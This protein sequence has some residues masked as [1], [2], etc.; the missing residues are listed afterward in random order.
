M[1]DGLSPLTSD[2]LHTV[3]IKLDKN[4]FIDS[5]IRSQKTFQ[6]SY[7][8]EGLVYSESWNDSQKER[9]QELSEI[10]KPAASV[11]A[12]S[13]LVPR[14]PQARSARQKENL[15]PDNMSETSQ[16]VRDSLQVPAPSPSPKP[17]QNRKAL[18]SKTPVTKKV[19]DPNP[20]TT[21]KGRK[22]QRSHDSEHTA[23][24]NE[25]KERRRAKQAIVKPVVSEESEPESE[26]KQSR[27]RGKKTTQPK[28]PKLAAGLS[29]MHGFKAQNLGK[30]RI[31]LEPSG[32]L[33]SKGRASGK[34]AVTK[35][36]KS[37]PDDAKSGR[38]TEATFLASG[39]KQRDDART[40]EESSKNDTTKETVHASNTKMNKL[41][42]CNYDIK[43]RT[44]GRPS[45]EPSPEPDDEQRSMMWDIERSSIAPADVHSATDRQSAPREI[46]VSPAKVKE[47]V[48]RLKRSSSA[49]PGS[50]SDHH[51]TAGEEQDKESS[52][53]SLRPSQSAS[54]VLAVANPPPAEATSKY[55]VTKATVVETCEDNRVDSKTV[56]SL[57]EHSEAQESPKTG[58]F[59]DS[60]VPAACRDVAS[61]SAYAAS[62]ISPLNHS[63][64]KTSGSRVP[65]SSVA[66]GWQDALGY[67]EPSQYTEDSLNAYSRENL[68]LPREERHRW[69]GYSSDQYE[70]RQDILVQENSDEHLK[71][72]SS[73]DSAMQPDIDNS[74]GYISGNMD[75]PDLYNGSDDQYDDHHCTKTSYNLRADSETGS[76]SDMVYEA[77]ADGYGSEFPEEGHNSTE[78]DI[79]TSS[80][81]A[82]MVDEDGVD[83][84]VYM[85]QEED[86]CMYY[87]GLKSGSE[88]S[89]LG[90]E[91]EEQLEFLHGRELLLGMADEGFGASSEVSQIP[92]YQTVL[93]AEETVA[94]QLKGHWQ[95]QRF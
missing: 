36:N 6:P 45:V 67:R 18:T 58:H 78:T 52:S 12:S 90:R 84:D 17:P 25:R 91:H 4:K 38:W 72:T 71:D 22:R 21:I 40:V 46:D 13:I 62:R 76:A 57:L 5:Y 60:D 35:G 70:P 47:S 68:S 32:G 37:R 24:L 26:P 93:K 49:R 44:S 89:G 81:G 88:S 27:R 66:G 75:A 50:P 34:T 14:V 3:S 33:Y 11:V 29:L 41:K 31:T 1:S 16:D 77:S 63:L 83:D 23:R 92:R 73:G 56:R 64:V 2:N 10:M 51:D 85:P 20:V 30:G 15:P 8:T 28:G 54:Q 7:R 80:I 94:R 95:P 69:Q 9:T 48:D 55:F 43:K 74:E 53:V 61:L 65:A 42:I 87:D 39:S 79:Q 82:P 19:S 86:Y 59:L